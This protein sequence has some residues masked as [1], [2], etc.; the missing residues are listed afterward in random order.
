M[1]SS[2]QFP[3]EMQDVQGQRCEWRTR[4]RQAV[5][6]FVYGANG[7]ATSWTYTHRLGTWQSAEFVPTFSPSR[8]AD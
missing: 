5:I 7:L 3:K 4:Q 8:Y 2:D 6:V 1:T